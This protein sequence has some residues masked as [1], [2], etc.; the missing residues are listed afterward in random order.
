MAKLTEQERFLCKLIEETSKVNH[1]STRRTELDTEIAGCKPTLPPLERL[2][3]MLAVQQE[4]VTQLDARRAST[5]QDFSGEDQYL[6]SILFLFDLFHRFLPE[7]D[8]HIIAQRKTPDKAIPLSCG[9]QIV[10]ALLQRGYSEKEAAV[11]IA[12]FFQLRRA[13]YF[14]GERIKGTSDCMIRFREQLWNNVFTTDLKLYRDHL[15]GKMEEY[16][17]L[18]LGPTGTGKG[19]SAAA[20][21]K[22]G[23]IPYN[24]SSHTFAESFEKSFIGINLSQFP[25]NLIE[26]ELFG[27]RKG[28]FTGAVEAHEGVF[29]RCNQF[30]SILL[31]E[32]GDVTEPVQIKLL[33]V[34]QERRF[35][36][37][38][39]HTVNSFR[40]RVIAATNRD[41]NVL[42]AE[43][44]FRDDFYYRLCSDTIIVPT[45][46]QR[47]AEDKNEL[48]TMVT[49]LISQ[50]VGENAAPLFDRVLTTLEKE[51]GPD[52][53]WPGNV[54]ELEQAVRSIIV[55]GGYRGDTMNKVGD[56]VVTLL[57][58]VKSPMSV[59]QL[60]AKYCKELYTRLNTYDAVGKS[61]GL[62]R[63]TVKKYVEASVK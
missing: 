62:D 45:L 15:M 43:G 12:F 47:I 20:I 11:H 24:I 16:A 22:S 8:A 48:P 50:I 25:E 42:R 10:K 7:F 2:K 52:Y 53:D 19:T 54:R 13:F 27:H 40:G 32:I 38:G 55:S 60:L 28:A 31:D 3:R 29:N 51:P 56:P 44:T 1:F 21:G 9:P 46:A 36:P 34:I 35:S 57:N 49:H 5:I 63:R 4:L 59:E 61:I 18:I 30:G 14:I 41:L 23:Y 39:S 26:S 17:T 37:V 6:V 58:S 33:K